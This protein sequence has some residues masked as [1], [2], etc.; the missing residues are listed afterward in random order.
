MYDWVI[1]ITSPV[2]ARATQSAQYHFCG[3]KNF[4][5][6]HLIRC[7]GLTSLQLWV[8]FS[9]LCIV[10]V[11]SFSSGCPQQH[12]AWTYPL[13]YRINSRNLFFSQLYTIS[14]ATL[15]SMN[16]S[17]TSTA[18]LS[19]WIISSRLQ[20]RVENRINLKILQK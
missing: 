7:E 12:I 6:V 19:S 20:P 18:F 11:P 4:K 17:F 3:E 1:K 15:T 9:T 13:F 14:E 5:K 16:S 2:F 8:R 10:H